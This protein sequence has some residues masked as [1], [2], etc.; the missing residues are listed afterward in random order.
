MC[1]GG[2]DLI[3]VDPQVYKRGLLQVRVLVR[4]YQVHERANLNNLITDQERAASAGPGMV[5]CLVG[6]GPEEDILLLDFDFLMSSFGESLFALYTKRCL[7]QQQDEWKVETALSTT[8][9]ESGGDI[10]S[11]RTQS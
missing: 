2:T 7:T 9:Y 11:A 3:W 1:N 10:C 5:A 4:C 6:P 8:R